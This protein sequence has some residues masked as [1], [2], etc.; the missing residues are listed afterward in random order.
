M[1]HPASYSMNFLV[2]TRLVGIL[3]LILAVCGA[4]VTLCS[5]PCFPHAGYKKKTLPA[6]KDAG[7]G[8]GTDQRA[9]ASSKDGDG[10]DAP[11]LEG[12][13]TGQE[14]FNG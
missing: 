11:F 1:L 13:L 12:A 7:T 6:A 3:S 5:C 14:K 2:P 9:R 4:A 8:T 10:Q